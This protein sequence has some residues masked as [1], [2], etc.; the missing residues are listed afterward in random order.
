MYW[1]TWH[2]LVGPLAAAPTCS[3]DVFCFVLLPCPIFFLVTANPNDMCPSHQYLQH[4]PHNKCCLWVG[5]QS[6]CNQVCE[7][8]PMDN[9]AMVLTGRPDFCIQKPN[10][11][12]NVS[13]HQIILDTQGIMC[14]KGKEK[15]RKKEEETNK[16]NKPQKV[17]MGEENQK[18]NG[19]CIKKNVC[20]CTFMKKKK[21]KTNLT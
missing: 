14:P 12:R 9:S 7:Y 4:Q 3:F 21:K 11:A 17:G 19:G 1:S 13:V 6:I 20:M 18:E 16:Q 15:K 2:L 10:W 8:G 5:N